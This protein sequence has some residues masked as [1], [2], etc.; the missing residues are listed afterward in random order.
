M[1]TYE[2]FSP[3]PF[4]MRTYKKHRGVG[5][6]LTPELA[7]HDPSLATV[8]K[9]FFFIVLRTLLHSSK[10]QLFSFQAISHSFAKNT[11]GSRPSSQTL[12]SLF[13]LFAPSPVIS[14]L[15]CFSTSLQYNRCAS[16]RRENEFPPAFRRDTNRLRPSLLGRQHHGT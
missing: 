3:K 14:L 1:R 16:I 15:P 12:F 13:D 7:T 11:R 8:L 4:R 9:S 2:S 5:P 6:L 10:T